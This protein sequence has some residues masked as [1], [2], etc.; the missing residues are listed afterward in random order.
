MVVDAL[1]SGVSFVSASASNGGVCNSGVTCSLG[2]LTAGQVVIVTIVVKVNDLQ[3]GGLANYA[4]VSASNPDP[5]PNNNDDS[6]ITN[7]NTIADISV[8]KTA[9][10][11]PA[12]P[13]QKLTYEIVVTNNGPSGAQFVTVNDT[14]PASLQNAV[15]TTSQGSCNLVFPSL[16]CNL[17][18]MAANAQATITIAGTLDPAAT[19]PINNTASGACG[20]CTSDPNGGNNTST[21]VTQVTPIA[22]LQLTKTATPTVNAGQNITYKV[23]VYNLGPSTAKTVEVLDTLPPGVTYQA[24]LS[25][26]ACGETAP[27]SGVIKCTAATLAAGSTL[28]FTIVVKTSDT[29]PSGTSLENVAV[30]S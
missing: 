23:D 5:S 3:F 22:D 2:N 7:V 27:N 4:R 16:A 21:V 28:S 24:G 14:L 19:G 6:E 25:S 8:V 11:S 12:V 30:V 1:P 29:I 13:G 17:G 20:N 26:A 15:V 9:S 10:P 18:A